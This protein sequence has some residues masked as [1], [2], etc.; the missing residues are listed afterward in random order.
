MNKKTI[1]KSKILQ[2]A[3]KICKTL[4][5]IADKIIFTLGAIVLALFILVYIFEL[6]RAYEF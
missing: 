6:W 5:V 4:F 1:N 3:K 2:T